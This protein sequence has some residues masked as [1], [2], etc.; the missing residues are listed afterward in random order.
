MARGSLKQNILVKEGKYNVQTKEE[1]KV[2]ALSDEFDEL[3]RKNA[4]LTAQLNGKLQKSKK[5]KA[6]AADAEKWA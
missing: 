5:P 1:Q 4:D 3:K 2:I 6:E